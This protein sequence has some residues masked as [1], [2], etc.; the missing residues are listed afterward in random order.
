MESQKVRD[1]AQHVLTPNYGVR[2]VM[3]VRGEG[4][5]VWDADGREYL[6]FLAGISVCSLGHCHPAV[7]SAIREQAGELVHCSNLY[8]IPQQVELAQ[9]LTGLCFADRAFF[10]NSG[11]EVNEGAI[12]L[13]RLYSKKKYGENRFEIITLRNS[14]HG[15]T[16][17]TLTAT[18][19]EK[20]QKGFEPLLPGFKYAEINQI[21]SVRAQISETTCAIMLEPVQ[22]EGGIVACTPEFLTQLREECDTRN[23]LLIF[24]EIQCGMG[25]CGRMFAHQ[26]LDVE[27]DIMTLAKALGNGFP[28]GALLTREDIA[29]VL[30]PG[31]HGSTFGGNPLACAA[32][33]AVVETMVEKKLPERAANT[34]TYFLQALRKAIAGMDIVKEVRGIGLMIGIE[35]TLPGADVVKH[36]AERGLLIN[37]TMGHVLRLLPAL[38]VTEEQCDRAVEIL[39]G[40]LREEQQR[41]ATQKAEAASEPALAGNAGGVR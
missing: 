33:L 37:C 40:V 23:L 30:E 24:D 7:T 22:G 10:A 9:K 11:A 21:E 15:R 1:L 18:G 34:G 27:P 41:S 12:K 26:V 19:Q 5:R 16:M 8:L 25:R 3:L 4:C 35:L 39:A 13:A 32:A 38:V 29:A 14:F 6:D 28:I 31:T 36:C 2:D 17:A 20:I